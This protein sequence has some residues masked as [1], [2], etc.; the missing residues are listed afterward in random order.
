ML[1]TKTGMASGTSGCAEDRRDGSPSPPGAGRN[2]LPRRRRL[3][4]KDVVKVL[5]LVDMLSVALV[6]PLL[7]SYFRDLN[8]R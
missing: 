2:K 1:A 8:I 6:V 7:S 4:A 3:E 5:V